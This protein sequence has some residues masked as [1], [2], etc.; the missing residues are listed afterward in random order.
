M[1][2]ELPSSDTLHPVRA[3]VDRTGLSPDLL[4]AWE[5]R[6][7]AV[8]PSRS[9]G[10]QRLYSDAD[11]TRLNL[12]RQ[13]VD[14]GWPISHVSPYTTEALQALID[15]EAR[16]LKMASD[17]SNAAIS[18]SSGDSVLAAALQA[19]ENYDDRALEAVLRRAAL[20]LGVDEM[21]E[22]VL[23]PLLFTIGSLWHQ[24]VL[25]PASEH[26]ASQVIRQTLGRMMESAQAS[27]AAPLVVVGTPTGHMHELGAMLAAAAGATS[28]WRVLYLGG[29]LPAADFVE[30]A[31]RTHAAAIAL[32]IVVPSD[33]VRL[34]GE[35]R[36]LRTALPHTKLV[37][38]GS[39]SGGYERVLKEVDAIRLLTL[40]QL[41]V[42][43][44]E[45]LNAR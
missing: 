42:W 15:K 8:T 14:A 18:T 44:N 22:G 17:L 33:D 45:H 39:G 2:S 6:Y 20:Y 4:R 29:N 36:A 1:I 16:T 30:A 12:L 24:G 11:I 41:R 7:N 26:M 31:Q 40:V 9:S 32:S 23:S 28:G 13:A 37:V 43:F 3:V 5:R 27:K 19:V 35:L 10:R 25:R 34:P 21:L 38:G